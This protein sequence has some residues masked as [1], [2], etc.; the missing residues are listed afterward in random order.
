MEKITILK[1]I[2]PLV[3]LSSIFMG[4]VFNFILFL[5]RKILN[6][7]WGFFINNIM[8]ADLMALTF[9]IFTFIFILTY[10]YSEKFAFKPVLF[11]GIII[12]GYCCIYS[13]FAWNWVIYA[14]FFLITGMIM[15]S[16]LPKIIELLYDI[17]HKEDKKRYYIIIFPL[18][19][20]IWLIIQGV[21]F[22]RI[23]MQSWRVLYLIIGIINIIS[24]PMILLYEE[25]K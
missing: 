22:E 8:F 21:I 4:P 2:I 15:G 3:F 19:A 23:G 9:V 6:S 18:S 17:A 25:S 7:Y 12:I 24:A 10:H 16:I 1:F 14:L 13:A 5:Y 20:I 11:L